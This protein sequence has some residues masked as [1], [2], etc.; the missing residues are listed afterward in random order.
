MELRETIL[1]APNCTELLRCLAKNGRRSV[2]LRIMQPAELAELALIRSGLPLPEDL[3][4][5]ADEA[6]VIYRFLPEISSYFERPN[7]NEAQNIADALYTLR[8]Q[9]TA[10]QEMTCIREVLKDSPFT[11]KN[12][13]IC[14]VLTRFTEALAGRT[15][16]IGLLRT[17]L[18]QCSPL[19]VEIIAAAEFPLTPLE[20]ALAEKLAGGQ[21]RVQ[22]LR[23]IC[24]KEKDVQVP[25][26]P[27]TEAYGSANE[28]EAVIGAIF[29]E[30]LHFDQCTVA[31]TDPQ[32]DAP[33]LLALSGRYNIPMTFGCGLPIS[34]SCAAAVLRC[35]DHWRTDGCFGAEALRALIGSQG[36]DR[37]AFD[38][39]YGIA[40]PSL[41]YQMIELAG[42]LRLTDDPAKNRGILRQYQEGAAPDP[43]MLKL[44]TKIFVEDGMRADRLVGSYAKIRQ[45]ACKGL[46]TAA[47]RKICDTLARY[48]EIT[49]QTGDELIP[50]LLQTR[51][52]TSTSTE[53]KLH[54]TDL[55]GA[56]T[57]LRKRLF[58]MGMSAERFPG[59]CA[60]NYLL[61]D[62]EL[63]RF[64]ADAPTSYYKVKRRL[65]T[66]RQLL[67]TAA[68]FGVKTTAS[69]SCYDTAELKANNPSSS[70]TAE[71]GSPAQLLPAVKAGYFSQSFPGVTEI[72]RAYL[73]GEL[74]EGSEAAPAETAGKTDSAT[75]TDQTADTKPD[76]GSVGRRTVFSP[77][78]VEAFLRCPRSFCFRYLM[79]MNPPE[80][81][82][83]D[84]MDRRELGNLVHEA[85]R[86]MKD[87]PHDKD[88]FKENA[89]VLFQAYQA[90]HTPVNPDE[91]ARRET[92]YR[93][94]TETGYDKMEGKTLVLAEEAVKVDYKCGLSVR[95]IP[96][97]VTDENGTLHIYDYKTKR[98]VEHEQN[99]IRSCVQVCLYADMM[100][101]GDPDNKPKVSGGTYLYLD[102]NVTVDCPYTEQTEAELE[103]IMTEL[104]DAL[105]AGSFPPEAEKDKCRYCKFKPVCPEGRKTE[106]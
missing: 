90:S 21:L 37:V 99:D 22:T 104:A 47:V 33:L 80:E 1:L 18:E 55:E 60:E 101:R 106:S 66:W 9:I 17:A 42:A 71:D 79:H 81:E 89:A 12:E 40:K 91:V 48:C 67:K 3:L 45:N 76:A 26:P 19:G 10:E 63:E 35:W 69:Y 2:G 8:L 102:A 49:G 103:Q 64:G 73:R 39:D 4:S 43:D 32:S 95:G 31:L 30:N 83:T 98:S 54:V 46:D 105:R 100:H 29:A 68:A 58:I 51:V 70:L 65:N 77:T 74:I 52:C 27:V 87:H 13:A 6:A 57:S 82:S 24:G 15:D 28:A 92:L 16:R 44:L 78:E 25:V 97:A 20:R 61:L 93:R 41:R 38:K 7:F 84:F 11:A 53:G 34:Y 85:L 88:T 59:E 50:Q 62:R 36:F 56:V 23:E 96:D 72:G 5:A 94:C 75:N 14:E 86:W